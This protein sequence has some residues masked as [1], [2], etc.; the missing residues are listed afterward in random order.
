M[1]KASSA[2]CQICSIYAGQR[3]VTNFKTIPST[4]MGITLQD[5][6]AELLDIALKHLPLADLLSFA[7]TSRSNYQ[8]AVQALTTL[9]LAVF[10]R[11]IH[12]LLAFFD[13][14]NEEDEDRDDEDDERV[15][16][17]YSSTSSANRDLY[18]IGLA[19][20]TSLSTESSSRSQ[21]KLIPSKSQKSPP[22]SRPPSSTSLRPSSPTT[23][24]TPLSLR[25]SEITKQN[26][27][28]VSVLSTPALGSLRHL[29]LRL[30]DLT[31]P[32]LSTII[33][34]QFPSMQSLSL[35]FCHP[36]IH[37]TTLPAR[38]WKET[39]VQGSPVWNPLS[40]IG[41]QNVQNL[42][43]RNL[44]TLRLS[45]ANITSFQLRRWIQMNPELCELRLSM[46]RGVD[47][48]F[49]KWLAEY[50][51]TG[52]G[53]G[54]L[55]TITLHDCAMLELRNVTD[56]AWIDCLSN[57]HNDHETTPASL[58]TLSLRGCKKVSDEKF[59]RLV[60]ENQWCRS[61]KR[62]ISP[63][64]TV[65]KAAPSSSPHMAGR[66]ETRDDGSEDE[67]AALFQS[68]NHG[69]GSVSPALTVSDGMIGR[70]AGYFSVGKIEVDPTIDL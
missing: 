7:T 39:P 17:N 49:A 31:S 34:R 51:T 13:A 65:L 61:I 11:K 46:C 40:A 9:D 18:Q 30:Y 29:T 2:H 32:Q 4:K 5:L 35:D 33:A 6:P 3:P 1:D 27:L 15:A 21:S 23:P 60:T 44:R 66:T 67:L 56:F 53:R 48:E 20:P 59:C 68:R 38:Y 45:R 8:L 19:T 52:P 37:D 50:I 41:E 14:T 10:P 63:A 42:S 22:A 70:G 58:K 62:L 47:N 28:A 24:P 69:N 36:Y 16:V 57:L 64:G 54:K 43:L 25:T 55:E 12:S 26:S